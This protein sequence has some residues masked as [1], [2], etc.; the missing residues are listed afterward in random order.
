MSTIQ[1]QATHRTILG[2]KV[3]QLRR[4]GIIPI[5]LYGP[6]IASISLQANERALQRTL[7]RSG[8]TQLIELE[9]VPD[10]TTY[11]TLAREVQLDPLTQRVLH[12]D[13][14]AVQMDRVISAAVP[15]VFE[16]EPPPVQQ[17][18]G[19][20][21]QNIDDIEVEAMPTELP[22]EIRVDLSVIQ[23]VGHKV[24]VEELSLA[25]GIRVLTDPNEWIVQVVPLRVAEVEVIEAEEETLVET[26][27]EEEQA[28]TDS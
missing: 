9:V 17:G 6:A 20:L 2:K 11:M 12:A 15:L 28:E 26:D 22:S 14:Q 23:E 5:A 10:G 24:T 27:E 1:M 4:A 19:V 3:R 16:G 25:P 21:V 13:F 7:S 18:V 8:A